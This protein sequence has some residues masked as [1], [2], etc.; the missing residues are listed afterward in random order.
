MVG[1]LVVVLVLLCRLGS[2]GEYVGGVVFLR[3]AS[4]VAKMGCGCGWC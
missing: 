2:E 1:A 3:R 4:C